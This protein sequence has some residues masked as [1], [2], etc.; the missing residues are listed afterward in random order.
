MITLA[1]GLADPKAAGIISNYYS[2]QWNELAWP[3]SLVA[4]TTSSKPFDSLKKGDTVVIPIEP[5]VPIRS[6]VEGAPAVMDRVIPATQSIVIDQAFDF[7]VGVGPV[8]KELSYVDLLGAYQAGGRKAGD[9]YINQQ[10]FSWLSGKATALNKGNAAGKKSGA[11]V[12]G[13]AAAPVKV[14][15]STILSYLT[16]F[17]SV[18]GEQDIRKGEIAVI[19]PDLLEW[20]FLNSELKAANIAG[21]DKSKLVSG[22]M[23]NLGR[24]KFYVSTYATGSGTQADPFHIYAYTKQA[25]AFT[26]RMNETD[27]W[28]HENWDVSARGL[29]VWG[30]GVIKDWAMCEGYVYL[31]STAMPQLT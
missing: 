18:L 26:M 10:F 14:G 12:L 20:M 30:R 17:T 4:N 22:Y 19:L 5:L 25:V 27:L 1:Q 3:E 24:Q 28:K 7:N 9:Q 2:S 21:D 8:T 11:F 16:Q 6:F 23:G 13:T 31:D 15:P 29:G